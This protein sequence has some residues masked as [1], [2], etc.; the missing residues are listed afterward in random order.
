MAYSRLG[1]MKKA[2]DKVES[3]AKKYPCKIEDKMHER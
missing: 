3:F 2:D 1:E